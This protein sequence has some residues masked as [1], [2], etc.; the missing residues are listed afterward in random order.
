MIES[1]K[2]SMKHTFQLTSFH[3]GYLVHLDALQWRVVVGV[4]VVEITHTEEVN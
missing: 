1:L 2:T 3:V 4:L